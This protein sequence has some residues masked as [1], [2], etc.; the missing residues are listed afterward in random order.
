M[1][2]APGALVHL[3]RLVPCLL[4]LAACAGKGPADDDGSGDSTPEGEDAD[5]DGFRTP[6][7]CDDADPAVHEGA[8]EVCDAADD[9]ENCNGVADDADPTV[10]DALRWYAD[11]DGD[12]YG[13]TDARPGYACDLPAGAADNADDCDDADPALSPGAPELCDPAGV[14]EDC[15]GLVN[16]ADP[17]LS[18]E[19][20][21][22]F[23]L[24]EDRDDYG[25]DAA[26][27]AACVTPPGYA[28]VAGDCDDTDRE[29][30]PSAAEICD[31][32]IDE[33]CLPGVGCGVHGT[34]DLST[35]ARAAKIAGEQ[36]GDGLVT[37]RAARDIDGDGY[38]DLLVGSAVAAGATGGSGEAYLL[39][40][41]IA[42]GV[43]VEDAD[44]RLPGGASGDGLVP[45]MAGVDADGDRTPDLL[46]GA[47]GYGT[48]SG[49]VYLV[50]GAFSATEEL[51]GALTDWVGTDASDALGRL[52]G[53]GDFD[54]DRAEDLVLCGADTVYVLDGPATQRGSQ[55]IDHADATFTLTSVGSLE[56][57]DVNG[58]GMDDL[59]VGDPADSGGGAA[60]GAARLAYGPFSGTAAFSRVADV[61][62]EGTV[63][64]QGVGS[65][66]AAGDLDG[67]GY[68]DVALGA[69]MD[70]SA[71][72]EAGAVYLSFGR[73]EAEVDLAAAE[74]VLTGESLGDHAG[75][76]LALGDFDG[77]GVLD[78]I[79]G[80][81]GDDDGGADAGA[82]Y[83]LY[84]PVDTSGSLL[85]ADAKL[86]GEDA[87][88]AAGE[89]VGV[90]G[91]IDGDGIEDLFVSAPGDDEGGSGA[92]AIYLFAGGAE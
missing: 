80:A 60:A 49:R 25:D 37:V 53:Y 57:F 87:D 18:T 54:G 81:S 2:V 83:V 44:V 22:T 3:L 32:G 47:P 21:A 8:A 15:D 88:D 17:D 77:D 52:G 56:V 73:F 4:L 71:A 34:T 70:G 84:G 82:A 11:A 50:A 39:Y 55:P 1:A 10:S 43:S 14:D 59:L 26:P 31:N 42:G 23:Y 27:L 68:K 36:A 78:L 28:D 9:D 58:D 89:A 69:S 19:G 51:G 72:S 5:G 30:N 67:D 61:V 35:R 16:D 76:S 48:D 86:V 91:D 20:L 74:V 33:D 63:A 45:L 75:A 6:D 64:G 62:F 92:G 13:P 46:V 79:V 85:G 24:D 29:I 90:A 38:D 40:G 12:G 66:V 65:A 7:D 41:P